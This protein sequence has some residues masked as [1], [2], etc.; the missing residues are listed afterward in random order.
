RGWLRFEE[1]YPGCDGSVDLNLSPLD[2]VRSVGVRFDVGS[3][4]DDAPV[5]A[6]R[7]RRAAALQHDLVL[8]CDPH[9]LS[10]DIR[11]DDVRWFR[12]F[13]FDHRSFGFNGRDQPDDDWLRTVTRFEDDD[14]VPTMGDGGFNSLASHWHR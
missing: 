1:T 5:A 13:G 2:S 6:Q 14:R 12:L 9:A 4:D 11:F 7:D 3:A 8:G 10:V